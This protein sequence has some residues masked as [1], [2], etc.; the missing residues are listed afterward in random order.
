ME[1]PTQTIRQWVDNSHNHIHNQAKA[2][3]IR[4]KLCTHDI[5]QYFPRSSG[6]QPKTADKNLLRP[7]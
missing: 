7:P 4:A 5:R 6:P 3:A 1:K 2:A